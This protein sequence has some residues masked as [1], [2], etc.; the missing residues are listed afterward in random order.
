MSFSKE[1]RERF[2]RFSVK[3][4]MQIIVVFSSM[5]LMLLTCAGWTLGSEPINALIQYDLI[6][7]PAPEWANS[8]SISHGKA[9]Y[10]RDFPS[11]ERLLKKYILIVVFLILWMILLKLYFLS[12]EK[13]NDN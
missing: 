5:I 6:N 1:H 9:V 2:L 12:D 10:Y 11:N 7:E 8:F 3:R 4:K 13:R